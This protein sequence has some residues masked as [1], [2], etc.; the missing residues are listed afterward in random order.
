MRFLYSLILMLLMPVA[1]LWFAWRTLKQTGHMD[2]PGE[3][4]GGSPFF[5]PG[6]IIWVHGASVGEIRAAAPLVTALHQKFPQRPIL[7][8]SFTGAGRAQAQELFG[9]RAVV[10][11][12]PYDLPFC[13]H[14]W[15][16]CVSP[17][18]GIIMETEIWPNLIAACERRQIPLLM[19]SAR[20]S[21]PALQRYRRFHSLLRSSLRRVSLIAAQTDADAE[22]FR[23]L[24]AAPERLQVTGNLKFDV[25][26]AD[27]LL[28]QG[29]ALRRQLFDQASVIVAGSTR[30]GEEPLVL[31]AFRLLLAKHPDSILVLAPRHPERAAAVAALVTAAGYVCRRRSAGGAALKSGE[32]LL[33]DRL[34]ELTRFYAAAELAF[35]GGSLVP[36]GGHNLLEPAALGLPVLTGPHLENVGDIAPI[37]KGAGGLT[38]V[39]DAGAL[40]EA[41]IWLVGN[42][43]TRRHIGQAAQ[44]TVIAN[45]G[46]L[47]RTLSLIEKHIARH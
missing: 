36:V 24:G 16:K 1:L 25:Q 20:L 28:L 42:P 9:E 32:V 13:V 47:A 31:E 10:S 38:V 3:R 39:P 33:L 43:V 23:Q 11:Q 45:R 37:L 17:V 26:F 19:V 35:V 21:Q 40:G 14:R 22:C 15:L 46:A 30:E 4:C 8:T 18:V 6:E 12:L 34:G 7:V 29:Q 5:P 44:Q 27:E 2:R 41:F